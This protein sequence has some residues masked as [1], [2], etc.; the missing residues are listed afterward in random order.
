[1]QRREFIKLTAIS[2]FGLLLKDLN[3][4]YS[5]SKDNNKY[6]ILLELKGGNDGLNTVIPFSNQKYYDLRPNISIDR[7][8]IIQLNQDIGLH[9]SLEGLVKS[10][11]NKELAIVQGIGYPN[12]NRSHFRSIDIWDTASDSEEI[13][14]DGWYTRAVEKNK[15]LKSTIDGIIIGSNNSEGLLSGTYLNKLTV[16]NITQLINQSKNIEVISTQTKNKSLAHIL[17]IQKDTNLSVKEIEKRMRQEVNL[18]VE[19]PKTKLG[20]H[21]KLTSELIV[22][23]VPVSVIKLSLSG[24]DTHTNQKE[25]QDKLLK[26]ISDCLFE[27]SKVM[28]ESNNWDNVLLMTYSEFGRRAGE[29]GNNGT[30]H[31]TA[32]SHF[33]LGGKVK[34]GLYGK[35]PSLTDLDNGDLKFNIDYRSLYNTILSK[36]YGN[37]N[38]YLSKYSVLDLIRI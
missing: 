24:F 29:N 2:S 33:I 17:K 25:V 22:N 4:N 32:S 23:K 14:S 36:W 11:K 37:T 10:W 26:E 20:Q 13:I 1:M 19:F 38:N 16:E 30:D 6:L 28:K 18:S 15:N 31:G 5:F 8:N 12:P 35:Q 21:F 9:P 7:S 27:F 34:G 3:F